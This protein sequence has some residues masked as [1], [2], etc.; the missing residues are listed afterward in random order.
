MSALPVK[1]SREVAYAAIAAST[2]EISV[3]IE[4]MP[5]ELTSARRN[6]SSEKITS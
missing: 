2:I 4:A 3:A 5:I 1:L 6:V